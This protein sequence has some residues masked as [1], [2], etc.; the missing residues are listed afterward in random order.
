VKLAM[1][2]SKLAMFHQNVPLKLPFFT[3]FTDFKSPILVGWPPF[4]D[5]STSQSN[6]HVLAR[7]LAAVIPS[8]KQFE[9]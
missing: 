7:Q 6:I 1:F 5:R 8:L 2:P 9:V 3:N 4:P